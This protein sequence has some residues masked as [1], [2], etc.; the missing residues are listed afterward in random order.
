MNE[1]DRLFQEL[2][3]QKHIVQASR[4]TTRQYGG[5]GLGLTLCRQIVEGY[6][7]RIWAES[8]GPG[9]GSTLIFTLPL[10]R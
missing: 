6:G 5:L 8:P 10:A 2:L 1:L 9:Q 4:G 7:G 3:L